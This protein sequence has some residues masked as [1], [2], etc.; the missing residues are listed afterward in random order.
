MRLE[1]ARTAAPR[2]SADTLRLE[3]L[4]PSNLLGDKCASHG[5]SPKG[6]LHARA[7][8]LEGLVKGLEVLHLTP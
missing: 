6:F 4:S 3:Y 2:H 8:F 1:T 5:L 7:P